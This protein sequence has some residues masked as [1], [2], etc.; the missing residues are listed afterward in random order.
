MLVIVQ[1]RKTVESPQ[2]VFK[3]AD[4][5]QTLFHLSYFFAETLWLC[6]R[7]FTCLISLLKLCD[8]VLM[9]FHCLISLLKLCDCADFFSPILFHC[10]NSVTVQMLFHPSY[11]IA[12]TLWLC[13]RCSGCPSMCPQKPSPSWWRVV[14]M[15]LAQLA[16][17]RS[18]DTASPKWH[19]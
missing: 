16:S 17:W 14:M 15:T 8:C 4:Y 1:H 18:V 2:N 3:F 9:L 6:R 7:C 13:R 12:E 5:V 19:R 11:I 10:W